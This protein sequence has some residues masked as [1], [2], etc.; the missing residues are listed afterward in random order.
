MRR[1]FCTLC[2]LAISLA[3]IA[4]A[5][6]KLPAIFGDHMV[7]QAGSKITVW[8]TADA[9]EH[10]SIKIGSQED[11]TVAG[12]DGKWIATLDPIKS[13]EAVTV[14]VKGNNEITLKDVLIGEVWLC[15]GQSNMQFALQRANKATEEI[16]QADYPSIRL[17]T[18]RNTAK[19]EPQADTQGA[20]VICSPKTAPSFSA[21]GYFF[22]RDLHKA[23]N[24]PV[25][26]IHSSWGG[27]PA[28]AWTDRQ[29]LEREPELAKRL[30]DYDKAL[31]AYPEAKAAYD[32]QV[33]EL[34]AAYDAATQP[35]TTPTTHTSAA[36]TAPVNRAAFKAP[37]APGGP[38]Q[39]NSPTNL[40]N[41]MIHPI[42]GFP[43]KG[44]IWYQ[45]ESNAARAIQYKLLLTAMINGWR[46]KWAGLNKANP[47]AGDFAFLIVQLA[48]FQSPVPT[49]VQ[50][51]SG[52]ALLREAQA[53]VAR[54]VP[55]TGLALAIDIGEAKDIHPKNKQEVGR[56][57]AL[58]AE[59]LVYNREVLASG[60]TLKSMKIDEGK[61]I[62]TFDHVGQGLQAKGEKLMGFAIASA[63][64][65]WE[66]AD[67]KIDGATVVL[68]NESIPH[69]TRVRY[70]WADNPDQANL[71]NS[72]DLPA[73]PFR[74]DR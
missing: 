71:Y 53:D 16:A 66:F 47:G 56:R 19:A 26:L 36:A 70:G 64:S 17:F 59:K 72:A 18:V 49:P 10:V 2:L 42:I 32:K 74:T 11:N 39:P 67:A 6:V 21:V 4:R 44:V 38:N 20:W 23:L 55:R 8:G 30:A 33:I 14:T 48:N 61:A 57:L 25:G 37:P 62:L 58:Q 54:E 22:G 7:L 3:G 51:T 35:A 15:S 9:G 45:G 46:A 1:I 31:A 52:W 29:S 34:K 65:P 40:Y 27:T 5:D 63:E 60:P 43:I 68:S 69:P 28:E 24:K 12:E 13:E 50:A 41:G 73:V